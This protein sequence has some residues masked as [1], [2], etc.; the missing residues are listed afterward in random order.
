MQQMIQSFMSNPAM[1][2]TAF[3]SN[4]QMRAMID[5][6]PHIRQMMLNPQLLQV[7]FALH[8]PSLPSHLLH[9]RC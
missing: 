3:D 9:S 2:E 7:F 1:M 5:A 8:D 6:N 4:P